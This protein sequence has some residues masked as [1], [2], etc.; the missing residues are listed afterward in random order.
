MDVGDYILL[1]QFHSVVKEVGFPFHTR[2]DARL[3]HAPDD[4]F[5]QFEWE[6][7]CLEI[8]ASTGA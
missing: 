8:D 7:V 3:L 1:A 4:M 6:G 5:V 2:W